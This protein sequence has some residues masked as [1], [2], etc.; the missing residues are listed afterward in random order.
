MEN[1]ARKVQEA[2]SQTKRWKLLKE[3]DTDDKKELI[4]AELIEHA[5][6]EGEYLRIQLHA[7]EGGTA[8]KNVA[9]YLSNTRDRGILAPPV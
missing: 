5:T 3:A 1:F 6:K 4:L 9:F 2:D 8:D 7:P